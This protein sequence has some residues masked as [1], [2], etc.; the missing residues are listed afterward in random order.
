MEEDEGSLVILE[1][2]ERQRSIG[3]NPK[4][5]LREFFNIPQHIIDSLDESDN[6]IWMIIHRLLNR[7]YRPPPK[8]RIPIKT[9]EEVVAAL[10]RAKNILVLT[11]AGVSTSCGIPDFRSANGVYARLKTDYPTLPNPEVNNTKILQR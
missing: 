2:L 5:I 10:K 8:P 4:T 9:I 1:W 7:R 3:S 11:G 6:K